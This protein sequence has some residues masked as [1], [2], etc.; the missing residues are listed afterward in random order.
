MEDEDFVLLIPRIT[1]SS[2]FLFFQYSDIYYLLLLLNL[3]SVFNLGLL[4]TANQ[5][6]VMITFSFLCNFLFFLKL[7][8]FPQDCKCFLFSICSTIIRY[9]LLLVLFSFPLED[10]SFGALFVFFQSDWFLA[11]YAAWQSFWGFPLLL[12]DSRGEYLLDLCRQRTGKQDTKSI[13]H[14]GNN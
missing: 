13:M 2:S 1:F 14:K 12:E 5:Q 3:Y 9:S 8:D 10:R 4:F 6:C 7:T 11:R